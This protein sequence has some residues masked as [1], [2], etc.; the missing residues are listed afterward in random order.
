MG[1]TDHRRFQN[2]GRVTQYEM[3]DIKEQRVGWQQ[4]W[5][6]VANEFHYHSQEEWLVYYEEHYGT[7]GDD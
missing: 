6:S 1:C 4:A 7:G 5:A 3:M 2:P